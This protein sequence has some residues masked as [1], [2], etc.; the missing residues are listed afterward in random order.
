MCWFQ[1]GMFDEVDMGGGLGSAEGMDTATLDFWKEL[2]D[3]SDS[4]IDCKSKLLLDCSISYSQT[5]TILSPHP[6][7]VTGCGDRIYAML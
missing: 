3:S 7:I 6:V 2:S 1:F 5:R 4:G